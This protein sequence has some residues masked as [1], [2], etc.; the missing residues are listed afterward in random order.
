MTE[1]LLHRYFA[2]QSTPAEA[3]EVLAWF[4]TEAGHAYLTQRLDR[5]LSAADWHAPPRTAPDPTPALA[6]LRQRLEPVVVPLRARRSFR[7]VA[8]GEDAAAQ[9]DAELDDALDADV[10]ALPRV[11]DLHELVEDELLLA[12][13]LV[14]R[15]E[16]CPQPLRAPADA[17]PLD[18]PAHPFAAL[19]A[20]R[21]G[22]LPS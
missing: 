1:P 4:D 10:L 2:N 3:Q 18:E 21:R 11:L 5:T 15:H 7:F 12:L 6:A 8:G 14:P 13:P 17:Q 16:V 20:L 19:D 22:T 9:L